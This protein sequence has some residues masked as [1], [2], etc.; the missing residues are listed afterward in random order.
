MQQKGSEL[1]MKCPKCGINLLEHIDVC[2]FCKTPIPKGGEAEVIETTDV[3]A[4]T[5]EVKAS[6]SKQNDSD[7]SYGQNTGRY[8]SIDPSKDSYDFDLQYTLTFRDSGE[9]KQAIADMDAEISRDSEKKTIVSKRRESGEPR[10]SLEEMQEAALRAQQRR[11]KRK[12]GEKTSK[13]LKPKK[14]MSH[15][16][17]RKLDALSAAKAPKSI[18]NERRSS[19]SG[20][21]NRGILIGAAVLAAVIAVI[22]CTVNVVS[23]FA[24]KT[25]EFP[26]VYTKSNELYSYYDGDEVLLSSNFVTSQL[27]TKTEDKS[28]TDSDSSSKSS[29]SKSSSSKTSTKKLEDP[30][31]PTSKKLVQKDFI[32]ISEDG[33]VVY[34]MENVNMNTGS[35]DL[36]Y[37]LNGKKK[38]KTTVAQNVYY[39]FIVSR[40]G[41]SVLYLKNTD[42][43]GAHGELCRW[44]VQ[45]KTETVVDSDITKGNFKLASDNQSVTYIKNFNPIVH[46][47]DLL[48]TS[49]AEGGESRRRVDEKVAFVFGTSS[50][51]SVYFY[52]KNYDTKTGTYDLYTQSTTEGPKSVSEKAFLAPVISSKLEAA[53]VYG[54]YKNNFQTLS[55]LD[56]STGSVTKLSDEVSEIIKV[57]NDEG[58]VVYSKAYE[59]EKA[60]YYFVSAKSPNSQK[61][62]TA[63]N[64]A[65]LKDDTK[66]VAFDASAD[67]STIAYIGGYDKE[68]KRGALYTL[69]IINDYAGSEKRI[70]DDAYT[71]NVSSDGG[72][73]RFASGYNKEENTVNLVSYSNTN[74]LAL[75]DSAGMGAFT[76][77]KSGEFAVLAKE[78]V[79]VEGTDRKTASVKSVNKK[80]KIRD[81]DDAVSAYGLKTDGT[82]LLKKYSE[83]GSSMSLYTSSVKGAKVKTMAENITDVLIY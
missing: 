1:I 65:A 59:T 26:T 17:K 23:Y 40:D 46:T 75:A 79:P 18:D 66:M 22:V 7:N 32:K 80:A 73:V 27:E 63:I 14:T 31:I 49:F 33:S 52:A 10:Y 57:R 54:D 5:S 44:T 30:K 72:V 55:Y 77:D 51:G 15:T 69:S 83:D 8:A 42:D 9:I 45:D 47:G 34:F 2:P 24:H 56:L 12:N 76:F 62:A 20:R 41:G 38:S 68:T 70:S 71:C 4:K 82:I 6:E 36:V 25:P 60:D 11:E 21:Q 81:I 67:F 35:G 16:E 74:T 58:A 28:K 61:V 29:S 19:G 64:L 50:K 3:E 13:F 53:Y 39:D 78:F 48:Y 37:Y 43:D